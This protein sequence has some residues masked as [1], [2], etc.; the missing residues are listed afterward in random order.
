MSGSQ[1]VSIYM[2]YVLRNLSVL[3][4]CADYFNFLIF[5]YCS[6]SVVLVS[7]HGDYLPFPAIYDFNVSPQTISVFKLIPLMA[8]FEW[9]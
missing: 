4:M 9:F 2:V 7:F 6:L 8:L 3:N 5:Q 1:K